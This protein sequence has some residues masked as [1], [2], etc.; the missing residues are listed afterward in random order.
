MPAGSVPNSSRLYDTI[1]EVIDP[2]T[3]T[4]VARSRMDPLVVPI[5]GKRALSVIEVD[6]HRRVQV[7]EPRLSGR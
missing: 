4:L 1:V 2:E 5:G 6:G 3:G 7:W